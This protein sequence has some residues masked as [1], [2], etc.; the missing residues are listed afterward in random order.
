MRVAEAVSRLHRA[1][2]K[3]INIT[4]SHPA[5]LAHC[6]D[7]PHWRLVQVRRTGS[8]PSRT[9]NNYHGSIS[10]PV[11][12]FE[13]IE[14]PRPEGRGSTAVVARSPDRATRPTEGLQT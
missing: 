7:S 8:R 12:S 9:Y 4:A 14:Q 2:N 3:R 6:R 11:V 10:R 5:V 1:E 13:F